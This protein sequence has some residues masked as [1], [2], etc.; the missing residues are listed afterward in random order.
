MSDRPE[1]LFLARESYRRRRLEDGARILPFVAAFLFAVPLFWAP[2]S[3]SSSGIV[4]LFGIWLALIAITGLLARRLS[5][6]LPH[7]RVPPNA[8]P[9]E[10][11]T[12]STSGPGAGAG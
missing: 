11:S 6:P 12:S 3:S 2:G 8:A 10:D 9:D 5:A 7:D 1:P 4:F